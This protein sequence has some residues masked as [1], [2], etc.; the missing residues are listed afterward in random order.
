MGFS[1]LTLT[2]ERLENMRIELRPKFEQDRT[3]LI[4]SR[5]GRKS[6]PRPV[7]VARYSIDGMTGYLKWMPLCSSRI[8]DAVMPLTGTLDEV[9]CLRCEILLPIVEGIDLDEG[10]FTVSECPLTLM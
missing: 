2:P 3:S 1:N 7:H 8:E 5:G 4:A 10:E 6:N 9:T